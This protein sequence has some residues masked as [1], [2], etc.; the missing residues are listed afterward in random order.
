MYPNRKRIKKPLHFRVCGEIFYNIL[1]IEFCFCVLLKKKMLVE[2][3][4]EMQ[5]ENT[6]RSPQSLEILIDHTVSEDFPQIEALNESDFEE[7]PLRRILHFLSVN[8]SQIRYIKKVHSSIAPVVP[9]I[10][11]LIGF[12][13]MEGLCF[14][15]KQENHKKVLCG[16]YIKELME[17]CPLVHSLE[18]ILFDPKTGS[19]WAYVPP[20]C[21]RY[22]PVDKN[23]PSI[24]E[25][26]F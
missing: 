19:I 18:Y 20:K 17:A 4:L 10:Q 23:Q 2:K 24:R 7:K 16:Q 8:K 21:N 22:C 1:N 5:A 25:R 15:S 14:I 13:P 9:E 3:M 12:V 6:F 26:L 11:I